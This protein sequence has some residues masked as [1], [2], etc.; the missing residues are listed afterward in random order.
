M[1]CLTHH[2][3]IQNLGVLAHQIPGDKKRCPVDIGHQGFQRVIIQHSDAQSIGNLRLIVTPVNLGLL[4]NCIRVGKQGT[5]RGSI[6]RAQP[7]CVVVALYLSH[8][9]IAA[10]FANQLAGH[11][12]G[13]R[14]IRHIDGLVA[15]VGG[16]NFHR[17]M[18]LGGG[19]TTN[20]QGH[21]K[22]LALHLF[23]QSDHLVQ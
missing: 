20:H 7:H 8:K 6:G 14:G 21:I 18:G 22:A 11:A 16:G 9:G 23:A 3:I 5:A 12:H 2:L 13:A 10:V 1:R 4:L 15:L 19:G 17:R